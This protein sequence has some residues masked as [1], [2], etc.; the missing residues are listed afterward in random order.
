MTRRDEMRMDVIGV[1]QKEGLP[2][3]LRD[4]QRLGILFCDHLAQ[5]DVIDDVSIACA[6]SRAMLDLYED[7]TVIA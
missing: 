6:A 3:W 5:H 7:G 1:H 2:V 4:R